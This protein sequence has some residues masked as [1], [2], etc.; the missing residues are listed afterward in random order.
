M[1]FKKYLPLL[2]E[3]VGIVLVSIFWSTDITIIG[4][5]GYATLSVGLL[6]LPSIPTKEQPKNKDDNS[7]VGN[8]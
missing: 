6:L 8:S 1:K 3:G 2:I 5:L 4:V 7:G